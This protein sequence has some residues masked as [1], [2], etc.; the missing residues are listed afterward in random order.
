MGCRTWSIYDYSYVPRTIIKEQILADFI[1]ECTIFDA[2]AT[3]GNKP[4][5]SLSNYMWIEPQMSK[6]QEQSIC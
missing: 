6:E 2:E 1:S 3:N 5:N 4:N